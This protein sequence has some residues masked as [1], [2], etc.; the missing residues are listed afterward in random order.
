VECFSISDWRPLIPHD[1]NGIPW[2]ATACRSIRS[3]MHMHLRRMRNVHA[4][5]T[6]STIVHGKRPKPSSGRRRSCRQG[7]TDR[8]GTAKA[9]K[10][11]LRCSSKSRFP[12]AVS[13]KKPAANSGSG[14]ATTPPGCRLLDEVQYGRF[15]ACLDSPG[16]VWGSL[17]ISITS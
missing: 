9:R 11:E 1:K 13:A 10:P 6:Y 15:T 5:R 17:S 3:R 8:N 7:H 4:R 16:P 14:G 12:P 2:D